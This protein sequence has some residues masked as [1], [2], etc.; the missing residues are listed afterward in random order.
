MNE[1]EKG[2]EIYY[3]WPVL[4]MAEGRRD[5]EEERA[6]GSALSTKRFHEKVSTLS[7]RRDE[8]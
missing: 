3:H 8:K 5:L 2:D 4:S 1:L 7:F 6:M